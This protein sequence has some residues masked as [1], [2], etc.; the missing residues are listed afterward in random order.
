MHKGDERHAPHL[1]VRGACEHN[2]RGID[3]DLP[4]DQLVVFTGVSGSGKSSL[5]FDTIFRESERRFLANL[6]GRAGRLAGRIRRPAAQSIDGVRPAIAVD[7]NSHVSSS[8]STVGTLSEIGDELRLLFARFAV[9]HCPECEE[10]A[11]EDAPRNRILSCPCGATLPA[12][13]RSLF[14]FNAKEG[15]CPACRGLGEEEAVDPALL[16]ADPAKTLREGALVP[17]T[18]N[19]YIVYSQV[20]PES[21]NEVCQAH[22][23][24]IDIP[25]CDLTEEMRHVIFYGSERVKVAFGKHSLESRMK[26]SGIKAKPRELGYYRG[27]VRVITET[28]EKKRNANILR[29]VTAR[30]CGKCDGSRL[31][32][33]ARTP[34]LLGQSIDAFHRSTVRELTRLLDGGH[35]RDESPH[36]ATADEIRDRILGRAARMERLGLGHLV[37]SRMSSTLS[38]G[39]SRR[40]KLAAQLGSDLVG[41]NYILD[42]PGAGLHQQEKEA[43]F[44]ILC[45]LRDRGNSVYVVEHDPLFEERADHLVEIGPD[46]GGQGG[47]LLFSGPPA[48][49][50]GHLEP[51]AALRN[52]RASPE[53]NFLE[54]REVATNNLKNI[55]VR[56]RLGAVNIVCGLSGTGKTS[57]VTHSLVP[58][59]ADT[60]DSFLVVGAETIQHV[61]LVDQNP[62]GRNARSN[63]ATWTGIFDVIR[64]LFAETDAAKA[65]GLGKGHFSFNKKG[66]RCEACEGAG[67]ETI[68]LMD[69]PS[70]VLTCAQCNGARFDAATLAVTYAGH[71]IREVLECT[72]DEARVLF[73]GEE[74]I[75][76]VLEALQK[77]GLGY[78]QLGQPAPT[79]SGGEAQRLK[80]ADKL[81][82]T[83]LAQTGGRGTLIV[84]DE[85]SCGLHGRDVRVLNDALRALVEDGA[86]VVAADHDLHL[87]SQADWVIELGSEPADASGGGGGGEVM[88]EGTPAELAA[89]ELS[90]TGGALRKAAA[91]YAESE[92]RKLVSSPAVAAPSA[93]TRLVRTWLKGVQTHNLNGVDV[94]FEAG[95]LTAVTGVSG[96]GKTSLAFDTL[97]ALG[98]SRF[99]ESFSPYLRR[100]IRSQGRAELESSGG[101]R[102]T[103][104]IR[105]RDPARWTSATVGTAAGIDI[106]LRL[107][108]SRA[109]AR[110]GEEL[111]ASA[112]SF[113]NV[114]GACPDC[115]GRGE[116]QRCQLDRLVPQ[117]GVSVAEGALAQTRGGR[118]LFDA[119]GRLEAVL[120]SAAD[121]MGIDLE[122]PFQDLPSSA[123]EF[124]NKGTGE[125]AF[126]IHWEKARAKGEAA[127]RFSSIWQG[128]E[129]LVEAE[130]VKKRERKAGP[131]LAALLTRRPCQSC[132]GSRLNEHARGRRIGPW[133]ISDLR[134]LEVAELRQM[135]QAQFLQE[136]CLQAQWLH[137]P[138]HAGQPLD[139]RVLAIIEEI[140]HDLQ[141]RLDRLITLGLG[142]LSTDRNADSLS[143]GEA[144]RLDLAR[145]LTTGLTGACYVLDEPGLSL[146][147]GDKEAL[148]A[149]LRDLADLGNTVV[150]VDHD[151]SLIRQADHIID[152]GPGAGAHGGCVVAQGTVQ[153]LMAHA[154][155]RTGRALRGAV[156]FS[157]ER[158]SFR[159]S[160]T[161][162]ISRA[163]QVRGASLNNL[164]GVDLD[165]SYGEVL[166]ICGV[167][168]SGKST[169]LE[170]LARSLTTG[171]A[172]GCASFEFREEAAPIKVDARPQGRGPASIVATSLDVMDRVRKTFARTD[173][174]KNAG[175]KAGDFSF[176]GK[177]GCCLACQGTGSLVIA[178]DFLPD[179]HAV[180]PACDGTRYNARVRAVRWQG[181][182][183]DQLLVTDVESLARR[184]SL[185]AKLKSACDRLE[186]LGLGHLSLGRRCDTLSGGESQR[187]GIARQL[188][189]ARRADDRKVFIFDEPSRGLH[190]EDQSDL[191]RLFARLAERGDAVVLSE[192]SLP[193]ITCADR[194]VELGPGAGH[195]GGNVVYQGPPDQLHRQDTPTGRALGCGA[196][197]SA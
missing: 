144:R 38:S 12:I 24:S 192:H 120:L 136:Q 41:I 48:E 111:T 152:V 90:P 14:S 178:L 104:G 88:F 72:I 140:R 5:A 139:E 114:M 153:A 187:L 74:K 35:N 134:R 154:E 97:A 168:G 125:R 137:E 195:A 54:L 127:H 145:Q 93:R 82:Q 132:E 21:M 87:I 165:I 15:A 188:M 44:E 143:T 37:L 170:V 94:A 81:A 17:T 43:L 45:E 121:A 46:A 175:L 160:A 27:I 116:V 148:G 181:V 2:L 118:L 62:I 31:N 8:R 73:A 85:V 172:V 30:N 32:L 169:L 171:G 64:T 135:L 28:L 177:S 183:I 151:P 138:G 51:A 92:S 25:W 49:W 68:G 70:L 29:F 185:P 197:P 9:R 39:E 167:S 95:S 117:P 80:L 7:Q 189:S 100:E 4:H 60:R 131:Q 19:G 158:K 23:F 78:L 22:G 71:S 83:K 11:P 196:N 191:A 40:L 122:V 194:V 130:Y 156:S 36:A 34:K 147:A 161:S 110:P 166:A 182:S 176:A 155:S 109:T 179:A 10:V 76:R 63:P 119:G 65:A 67:S 47:E 164:Q 103:L 105:S 96:S 190:V 61:L 193:L 20:T 42:E 101:V 102:A 180:C 13:T 57:L 86:T 1:K 108:F 113:N 163:C 69:M 142:Y 141:P 33:A 174:A 149:V 75:T 98:R 89:R 107:L 50:G 18:P 186:E 150:I 84:L 146:H 184:F 56:F 159:A 133:T 162:Q 16:V 59:L 53:A 91:R 124:I 58:W 26:W 77:L 66:G 99:A 115:E 126:E 6:G 3:V 123:L 173:D 129:A 55:T 106:G 157:L 52:N 79:L 128:V 112:F